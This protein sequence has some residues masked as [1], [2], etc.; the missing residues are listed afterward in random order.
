M[1]QSS[2]VY[3]PRRTVLIRK[4]LIQEHQHQHQHRQQTASMTALVR[5][6]ILRHISIS[7]RLYATTAFN[8]SAMKLSKNLRNPTHTSQSPL[9]GSKSFQQTSPITSQL[10]TFHAT[11][12]RLILPALPRKVQCYPD[13]RHHANR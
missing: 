8:G 6:S 1:N 13:Q 11:S 10:A 2:L 4:Y 12:Q 9:S 3:L 5:P 7:Q